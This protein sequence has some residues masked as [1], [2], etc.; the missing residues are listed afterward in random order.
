[1]SRQ[2]RGLGDTWRRHE[3]ADH[4]LPHRLWVLLYCSEVS[5]LLSSG[6]HQLQRDVVPPLP[7]APKPFFVI[8]LFAFSFA[9]IVVTVFLLVLIAIPKGVAQGVGAWDMHWLRLC[10]LGVG[11]GYGHWGRR[12]SVCREGRRE[13]YGN[14]VR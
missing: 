13:G 1:M 3:A 9:L 7:A 5:L 8:P 11:E 12:D 6:A 4:R 14:V 10:G 2:R